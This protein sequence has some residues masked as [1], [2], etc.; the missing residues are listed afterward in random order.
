MT[1]LS[2]SM[3]R[4]KTLIQS[5]K[6]GLPWGIIGHDILIEVPEDVRWGLRCVGYDTGQVDGGA[7]V[8]VKVR[9]SMNAHMRN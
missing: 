7:S 9:R 2:W 1:P 5:Y 4:F 8:D 6:G 3:P